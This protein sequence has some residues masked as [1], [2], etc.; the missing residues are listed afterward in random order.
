L[1]SPLFE[2]DENCSHHQGK[3]QKIVPFQFRSEIKDGKN[4][5]DGE[6]DHFLNCFQLDNVEFVRANPIRGN[7]EAV[8]S[9]R[10]DPAYENDFEDR[11]LAVF[12]MAVPG[13]SHENIGNGQKHDGSH[14]RYAAAKVRRVQVFRRCGAIIECLIEMQNLLISRGFGWRAKTLRFG[15]SH[16]IKIDSKL[17][18]TVRGDFGDGAGDY[19]DVVVCTKKGA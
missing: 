15:R 14:A 3:S 1:A 9:E 2:N 16:E 7:L 8:F 19:A 10:Y 13:K 4:C 18:R 17:C 11:R 6:C 12:Q 5:E